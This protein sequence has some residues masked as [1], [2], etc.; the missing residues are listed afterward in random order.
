LNLVGHEFLLG[1]HIFEDPEDMV[2]KQ[3]LVANEIQKRSEQTAA[4]AAAENRT[5]RGDSPTTK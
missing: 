2:A 1:D 3:E 5:A 4:K